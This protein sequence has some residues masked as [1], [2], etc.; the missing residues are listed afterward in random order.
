MLKNLFVKTVENP[1][2]IPRKMPLKK[3][4]LVMLHNRQSPISRLAHKELTEFMGP[5]QKCQYLIYTLDHKTGFSPLRICD[6][7]LITKYLCDSGEDLKKLLK[8]FTG[9]E[10]ERERLEYIGIDSQKRSEAFWQFLLSVCLDPTRLQ[11]PIIVDFLK[12][13]A[14]LARPASKVV[15]FLKGLG[16]TEEFKHSDASQTRIL[17]RE[18][19]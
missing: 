1:F 16:Y 15:P 4:S 6:I 14:I 9:S 10:K 5:K 19:L 13:K 2:F 11:R 18:R 12:G 7:A 3:A 8:P 17:N